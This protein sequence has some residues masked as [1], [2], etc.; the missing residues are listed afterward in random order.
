MPRALGNITL[1]SAGTGKTFNLGLATPPTWAHF[2]V[3]EKTT[4]D[5]VA[6]FSFGKATA[7][8]Q[9][10]QSTYSDTIG[11]DSFNS[12]AHVVQHYERVGGVIT[13][14]LS[15]SFNSFTSS[16]IKL[17]V[18]IPNADYQVLVEAE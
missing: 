7:T 10:C 15:A 6:H 12:S 17:N 1:N 18:S 5:T 9:V 14:V 4:G 16:G 8:K 2:T 3:C 13:K 11:S